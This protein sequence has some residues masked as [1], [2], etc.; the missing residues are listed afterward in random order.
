MKMNNTS[1]FLCEQPDLHPV[2]P[3]F[4]LCAVYLGKAGKD[5]PKPFARCW[6]FVA[7]LGEI[8]NRNDTETGNTKRCMSRFC[9]CMC[10]IAKNDT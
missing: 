6:A 2:S 1:D 7:G 4:A 3:N 10:I 8:I 5:T 9:V